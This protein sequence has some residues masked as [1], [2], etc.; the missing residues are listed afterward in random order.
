MGCHLSACRL[1]GPIRPH[2]RRYTVMEALKQAGSRSAQQYLDVAKHHHVASGLPWTDRLQFS[3]RIS[4]HSCK[5]GLG[6]SKHASVSHVSLPRTTGFQG[7]NL[8]A[9][10]T[11]LASW[12]MLRE[13]KASRARIRHLTFHE[14]Q[15]RVEWLLR[16][17]KTDQAALGAI[18]THICSCKHHSRTLCPYHALL[19]LTEWPVA[20]VFVTADGS[21]LAKAGWADTFE[22]LASRLGLPLSYPNGGRA[23]TGHSA[24]AT[25]AQYLAS[26]GIELWRIQMFGGSEVALQYVRNAFLATLG[27]LA[28][29]SVRLSMEQALSELLLQTG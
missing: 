24:C 3:Y 23:F 1:L 16:S 2:S 15:M 21:A 12:W 22:A 6:P 14:D 13:I 10:A 9:H 26:R 19:N 7:P 20:P 8:S 5:R 4:V 29:E 17:S 18:R 11:V 27:A 28:P 25:G